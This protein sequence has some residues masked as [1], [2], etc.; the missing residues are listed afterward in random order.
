MTSKVTLKDIASEMNISRST[1]HRALNGKEG[2]NGSLRT[3]ICET[4]EEMGYKANYV[5]SS[6]KRKPVR[7]AVVLPQKEGRGRLYHKYF[8]DAVEGFFSEAVNLNTFI[9]CHSF[10]EESNEQYD[11]L[12]KLLEGEETVDGLLTMPAKNTERMFYMISRFHD[13]NIPVVLI[14]NDLPGTN[15]LCCIAPHDE[16]IGRLG[17]EILTKITKTSGKILVAAGNLDNASHRCNLNGFREF[18]EHNGEEFEIV[19]VHEYGNFQK[20]YDQAR[21]I[22]DEV[23][24]IVAF[25]AVTARD[26]LPLCQAVIDS[27]LASKISGVGSDLYPE[28]AKLLKEDVVQA[29]IYK[30]AFDKGL[31]GFRVLFDYV[32]KNIA[33]KDDCIIVPI[34]VIMKSN[35]I[36]FEQYL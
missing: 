19:E 25:Y 34:S 30:N 14:D 16:L 1:V 11:I 23:K 2:V 17:A 8:W 15:R 22:L 3:R 31:E 6:L 20:I 7:L 18:T 29:L 26:T 9:E 4:A 24:G 27:G 12:N 5:A 32:V 36:F 28:S 13:R 10:D 21:K 33:P 35:L